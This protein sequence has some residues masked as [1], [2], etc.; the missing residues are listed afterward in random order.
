LKISYIV[1]TICKSCYKFII[2]FSVNIAYTYDAL[3]LYN[4]KKILNNKILFPHILICAIK[5]LNY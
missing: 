1:Y 2:I 5:Y 3:R 4:N